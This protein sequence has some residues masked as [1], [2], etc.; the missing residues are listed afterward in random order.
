VDFPQLEFL[1]FG[2]IYLMVSPLYLTPLQDPV[3]WLGHFLRRNTFP[4]LNRVELRMHILAADEEEFQSCLAIATRFHW[5][6]FKAQIAREISHGDPPIALYLHLDVDYC[7]SYSSPPNKV[8]MRSSFQHHLA[9]V[10][11]DVEN[12][13]YGLTCNILNYGI[14]Q[15]H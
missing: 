8:E 14:T 7:V 15:E 9:P 2:R 11:E 5:S 13:E 3:K 1:K 12:V 6:S 10:F 4:R